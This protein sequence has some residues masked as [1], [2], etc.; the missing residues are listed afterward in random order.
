MTTR[1]PHSCIHALGVATS[2]LGRIRGQVYES[3]PKWLARLLW[4]TDKLMPGISNHPDPRQPV[5]DTFDWFT[6]PYQWHHTDDE[7][8]KWFEAAN[9]IDIIN[10]SE[11]KSRYHVGQGQGVCFTGKQSAT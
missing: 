5:C 9:L 6:P 1:M 2:P 3:G 11:I 4:Q 8:R 7:V 10:L